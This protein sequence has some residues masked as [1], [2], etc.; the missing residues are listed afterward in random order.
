M[1]GKAKAPPTP[2]HPLVTAPKCHQHPHN[3]HEG[4]NHLKKASCF[5]RTFKMLLKK[6]KKLN[7]LKPKKN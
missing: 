1:L 4:H 3:M 6:N 5:D 2:P 7:Q